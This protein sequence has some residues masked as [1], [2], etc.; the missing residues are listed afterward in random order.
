MSLIDSNFWLEMLAIDLIWNLPLKSKE[1]F[2]FRGGF[3][4]LQ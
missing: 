3:G 4:D 2:Y 1:V